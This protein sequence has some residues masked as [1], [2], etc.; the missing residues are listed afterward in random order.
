MDVV[1]LAEIEGFSVGHQ[2]DPVARTGCTVVL[3]PAGAVASAYTPGFAPGGRE[4]EALKPAGMVQAIHGLTLSGGSAF[5][6]AAASGV[7]RRLLEMG[8]GLDAGAI[9]VP[10]APGAVIYDYPANR[11]KGQSPN[12]RMGYEAAVKASQTPLLS[13]PF[14]AGYSARSGKLGGEELSSH[15]GIGVFGLTNPSGLK[16]AALAV[17]NPLGSVVN[18][19]SGEII[20][21]LRRPGG[22]LA[23][24]AEI[25]AAL[26]R[27][28]FDRSG[29]T[30]LAVVG[31]NAQIDK[32]NA[33][34]LARMAG[35]GIARAIYPA[36]LMF[37]GDTVFALSSGQ[38][39]AVDISYLGALGA[40]ILAEAI[41]RSVP[42]VV[43][44]DPDLT[45]ESGRPA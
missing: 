8:A 36:H 9:R 41:V 3:C 22:G 5:G 16:M 34:R 27:G 6:L 7:V 11:S 12:E 14:G 4:M 24:R 15:S 42:P 25:L 2:E 38:G 18:P 35:A 26:E 20:S 17:V 28:G 31:T 43:E 32:L 1:S 45:D 10:V 33:Y 19:Y 23:S 39:P 21:G 13:G 37:D 44:I 30:V 40:E 29:R